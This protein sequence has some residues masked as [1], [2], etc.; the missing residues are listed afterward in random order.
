VK[1]LTIKIIL[2]VQAFCTQYLNT[3]IHDAGVSGDDWLKTNCK[4]CEV[5]EL[6]IV[7]QSSEYKYYL[8][9]LDVHSL[10]AKYEQF[11]V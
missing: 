9:H 1:T 2:E 6:D 5:G 7:C 3:F 4:S 10:S 11:K 8:L